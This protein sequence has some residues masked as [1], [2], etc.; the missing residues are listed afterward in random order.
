[1][2]AAADALGVAGEAVE[3][4]PRLDVTVDGEAVDIAL[5]DVVLSSQP[6]IGSRAFWRADHLHEIVLSHIPPSAI[7]ICSL[8]PLLMPERNSGGLHA[9]FN[10]LGERFLVPIAPGLLCE[11]TVAEHR[12][13]QAGDSIALHTRPGTLALDG[14]REI[15]LRGTEQV[16]VKLSDAGPN[17]VDI[18]RAIGLATAAGLFRR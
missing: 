7:G 14:E 9:R 4:R 13:M 5:V 18:D 15:E 6:W 12:A 2:A 16:E 1:M 8:G 17:V 3:R 10:E 11:V